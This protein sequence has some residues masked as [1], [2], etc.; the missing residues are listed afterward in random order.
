MSEDKQSINPKQFTPEAIDYD[1]CPLCQ[2]KFEHAVGTPICISD[3]EGKVC[4]TSF[5]IV[6]IH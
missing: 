4:I 3:N 2:D 6:F 1:E 5:G